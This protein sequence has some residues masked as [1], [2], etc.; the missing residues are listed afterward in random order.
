LGDVDIQD[1]ILKEIYLKMEKDFL[2][3]LYLK[4]RRA[5]EKESHSQSRI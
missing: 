2:K 3:I 5:G 4:S 1:F